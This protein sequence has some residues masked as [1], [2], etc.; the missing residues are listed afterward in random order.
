MAECEGRQYFTPLPASGKPVEFYSWIGERHRCFIHS[1]RF[2]V[3]GFLPAV[4]LPT[5][6]VTVNYLLIN[7]VH[8]T[9]TFNP[10]PAHACNEK[11]LA[12]C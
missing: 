5:R 9:S 10:R 1:R 3:F 7:G 6:V 4:A 11:D 12:N 2:A 8:T